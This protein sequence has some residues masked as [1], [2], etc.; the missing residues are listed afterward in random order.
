MEGG[1]NLGIAAEN[2]FADE[3]GKIQR[4]A[5]K[6]HPAEEIRQ[7]EDAHRLW[8]VDDGMHVLTKTDLANTGLL[9]DFEL[10][11]IGRLLLDS[12]LSLHSQQS[13]NKEITY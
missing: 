7:A 2:G 8:H 10:G 1:H 13:M 4:V 11:Y 6:R 9:V 3:V 5:D 12:L